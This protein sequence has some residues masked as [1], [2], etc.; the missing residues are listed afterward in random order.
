MVFHHRPYTSKFKSKQPFSGL[1]SSTQ[2]IKTEKIQTDHDTGLTSMFQIYKSDL[3]GTNAISR[4]SAPGHDFPDLQSD[5]Y[6]MNSGQWEFFAF[7]H[8][9][10]RRPWPIHGEKAVAGLLK[11]VGVPVVIISFLRRSRVSPI[12]VSTWACAPSTPDF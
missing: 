7:L 4:K 3:Y 11:T 5:I 9:H 8:Y 10:T 2:H 12:L 1:G 6:K